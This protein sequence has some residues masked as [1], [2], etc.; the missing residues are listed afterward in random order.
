M[1]AAFAV[2]VVLATARASVADPRPA[3]LRPGDEVVAWEPVHVAGP[4]AGTKTCPVCTYL[5]APV[6][7]AVAK[8]EA[9]AKKLAKPLETIATAHAKGKLRVLLVVDGSEEPLKALAKDQ[10]VQRLMLCYPDPDRKEK[11]LTAYKIDPATENTVVLYQ[12][13]VV[14]QAWA[15]LASGDLPRLKAATDRYLPKR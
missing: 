12:D 10:G 3:G 4:H 11:Q 5:D 7:L 9:A 13:Y 6:L 8:D 2:F 14:K 1:R 15:G